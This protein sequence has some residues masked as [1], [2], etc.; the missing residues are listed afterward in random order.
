MN[1]DEFVVFY[2]YDKIDKEFFDICAKCITKNINFTF[3]KKNI[4]IIKK[5]VNIDIFS[6]IEN[7]ERIL[8]SN[9]IDYEISDEKETELENFNK[10]NKIISLNFFYFKFFFIKVLSINSD[11]FLKVLF[12]FEHILQQYFLYGFKYLLDEDLTSNN[13]IQKINS[14]EFKDES[15]F[16]VFYIT[17]EKFNNKD[18]YFL[19]TK[20]NKNFV[21]LKEFLN[22]NNFIYIK[23]LN[24]A[25][26]II[27]HLKISLNKY[28][29]DDN[30]YSFI[31]FELIEICL[32]NFIKIEHDIEINLKK[33]QK[34]ISPDL[35]IHNEEN[36]INIVEPNNIKNTTLNTTVNTPNTIINNI[37][38]PPP[39][40]PSSSPLI[41]SKIETENII[42]KVDLTEQKNVLKKN[43]NPK[44]VI[45]NKPDQLSLL[46]SLKN[47]I[48]HI[49]EKSAYSSDEDENIDS[50]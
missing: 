15:N 37:P 10:N 47:H 18:K 30:S 33:I 12:N 2:K 5:Y 46:Y 39:P 7:I 45:T 41:P 19:R 35:I 49:R 42:Q 20:K 38:P 3:S 40:L 13:H 16:D 9:K 6:D 4:N 36:L 14:D 26:K 29:N 50:K 27:N 1:I 34:N 22:E 48:K 24:N 25:N 21:E 32:N 28:L 43:N 17:K 11:S 8:I 31:P 44:P 23:I